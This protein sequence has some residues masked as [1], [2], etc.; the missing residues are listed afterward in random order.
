M[1]IKPDTW[2]SNNAHNPIQVM[3]TATAVNKFAH[4]GNGNQVTWMPGGQQL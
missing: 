4:A 3:T 1:A 2:S